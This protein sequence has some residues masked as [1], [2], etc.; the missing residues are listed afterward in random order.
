MFT[1]LNTNVHTPEHRAHTARTPAPRRKARPRTVEHNNLI[2][3]AMRFEEGLQVVLCSAG[4][5]KHERFPRRAGFRHL[6]KTNHQRSQR[7]LGFRVDR[8]PPRACRQLPQKFDF[9]LQLLAIDDCGTILSRVRKKVLRQDVAQEFVFNV[10]SF[11]K[12]LGE[13]GNL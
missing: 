8:N 4:L 1:R 2:L 3:V 13:L 9:L 5:G 7:G 11:D 12:T 10:L 6:G